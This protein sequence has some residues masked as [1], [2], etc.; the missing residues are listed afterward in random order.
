MLFFLLVLITLIWWQH[1]SQKQ[2]QHFLTIL[3]ESSEKM[4][5]VNLG[6]QEVL[7]KTITLLATKDPLAYQQIA[8]M[9]VPGFPSEEYLPQDDISEAQRRLDLLNVDE[10]HDDSDYGPT[11]SDIYGGF[12]IEPVT[13]YGS[14]P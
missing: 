9:E 5:R 10:E 8:A 12:G 11:A 14:H 4:L 1:R 13:G 2:T 7:N 3:N 6:T